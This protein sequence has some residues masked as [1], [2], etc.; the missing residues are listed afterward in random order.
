MGPK[1]Q[2]DEHEM[3]EGQ[4]TERARPNAAAQRAGAADT[5]STRGSSDLPFAD[6]Q[7][8]IS[9]VFTSIQGEGKLGG[10][11][12]HFIRLNGCNLR[13]RWCD[14]PYA[15][16][17]AGKE[18]RAQARGQLPPAPRS[19]PTPS[20]TSP[21]P[22][23]HDGARVPIGELLA[24]AR[25]SGAHHVVITGGEPLIF[26]HITD[27]CRGLMLAGLHV[28]VETAGTV[29]VGREQRSE[30]RDQRTG[31]GNE[32]SPAQ[33]PG[34]AGSDALLSDLCSLIS[35]SPKLANSTPLPG[36]P[37]DPTGAWR[38]RHEQRR[39]DFD[40]MQSL[41]DSAPDRQ[42]KFVL[43]GPDDLAEIESILARLRG[44][45]PHDILLMP[46]GVTVP[47]TETAA[48]VAA[49]A[50]RRGWRYGRRLHIELYG[51][52]RGT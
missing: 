14:T 13:C 28:T 5:G 44:W 51:N 49:A 19:T 40:A 25:A 11:R 15:S 21:L 33:Q 10:V 35:L 8:A 47:D 24:G 45:A 41:L 6:L 48:W 46:E 37:R 4:I 1:R 50:A 29:A 9:E 27:L 12:S 7:F 16:W 31:N 3:T 43:T 20:P 26:P 18:P 38:R 39:L 34:A 32:R 23:L 52:T 42:I 17:D 2:V 30:N 36:D 22:I